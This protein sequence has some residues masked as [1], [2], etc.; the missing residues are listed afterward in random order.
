MNVHQWAQLQPKIATPTKQAPSNYS[1]WNPATWNYNFNK[2]D[3]QSIANGI[4]D[5]GD[6]E[7]AA[8]GYLLPVGATG[9]F[10]P[11]TPVPGIPF[12]MPGPKGIRITA[13]PKFVPKTVGGAAS[14]IG[15]GLVI[16]GGAAKGVASIIRNMAK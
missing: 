8:G 3:A 13:R 12:R 10:E 4:D 9:G 11:K 7:I 15:G 2:Q 14:A 16:G 6:R 5:I 1:D